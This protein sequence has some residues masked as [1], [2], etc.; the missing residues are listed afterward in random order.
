MLGMPTMGLVSGFPPSDLYNRLDGIARLFN[1][2][3]VV[4]DAPI[5]KK[6]DYSS[7]D[8]KLSL[9]GCPGDPPPPGWRSP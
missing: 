9:R 7:G 2:R 8:G 6:P 4:Q 3:R 5:F 1:L